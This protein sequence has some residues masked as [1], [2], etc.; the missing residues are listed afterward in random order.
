MNA[1]DVMRQ[2]V[3]LERAVGKSDPGAIQAMLLRVEEGVLALERL[4]IET[5]RENAA[6]RQRIE[7]HQTRLVSGWAPATEEGVH[8]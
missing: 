3:E 6:L 1:A 7:E 2:L 8:G 5:L 4:T